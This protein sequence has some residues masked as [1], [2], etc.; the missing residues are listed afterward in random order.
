MGSIPEIPHLP[1]GDLYHSVSS[2][3]NSA[4]TYR[5]SFL[6]LADGK[7]DLKTFLV[8][9]LESLELADKVI[10]AWETELDLGQEPFDIEKAICNKGFSLDCD[11][12]ERSSYLMGNLSLTLHWDGTIVNE[13]GSNISMTI[14]TL[15]SQNIIFFGRRPGTQKELDLL[16]DFL[17]ISPI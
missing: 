14:R 10:T 11:K 16:F 7:T 3:A 6:I 17:Q 1:A 13:E 5:K 4:I 15:E 9:N 8:D 2:L 12:D